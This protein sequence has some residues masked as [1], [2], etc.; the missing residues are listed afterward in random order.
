MI[1]SV[2]HSCKFVRQ[3]FHSK[4]VSLLL[5]FFHTISYENVAATL[6]NIISGDL[7]RFVNDNVSDIR[8]FIKSFQDI[9]LIVCAI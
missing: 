2:K 9:V 5:T 7:D 6:K 1:F 4:I 3:K 8:Y